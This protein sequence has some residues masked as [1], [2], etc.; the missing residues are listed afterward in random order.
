MFPSNIVASMM[1]IEDYK[2][3]EADS[4]ARVEKMDAKAMFS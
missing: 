3:F 4:S 1:T 2:M